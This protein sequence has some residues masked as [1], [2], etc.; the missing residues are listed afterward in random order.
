[1]T[2]GMGLLSPSQARSAPIDLLSAP[3][4]GEALDSFVTPFEQSYPLAWAPSPAHSLVSRGPSLPTLAELAESTTSCDD[5][6]A[7]DASL[8]GEPRRLLLR[9]GCWLCSATIC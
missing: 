8:N 1:M 7:A 6:E 4:P 2:S 5:S 9:L 3:R